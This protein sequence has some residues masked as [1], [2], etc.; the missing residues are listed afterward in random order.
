MEIDW[1]LIVFYLGL[2]FLPASLLYSSETRESW[3]EKHDTSQF[4]L[5]QM[6]AS[7]QNWL[8]LARA[9]WAGSALM[10]S[11]LL[12]EFGA[13]GAGV[14]WMILGGVF[15]VALILQTV[16]YR[17]AFYF[18]APVFFVWGLTLALVAPTPALFAI[19][20][21]T[22]FARLINHIDLKFPLL[23]IILGVA[24]YLIGGVSLELIVAC[25]LISIPQIVAYAFVGNLFCCSRM[26]SL[27]PKVN[28][29]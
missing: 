1:T 24:G 5:E 10:G 29:S 25:A 4:R 28:A 20:F 27:A 2:L 7:W 11:S 13:T 3:F 23:V 18:S 6:C 8:D 26:E 16:Q 9:Y 12:R 19:L 15:G 17:G 21:I 14:E 22:I